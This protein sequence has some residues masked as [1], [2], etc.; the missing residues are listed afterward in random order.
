M[1]MQ[2]SISYAICVHNEHEELKRLLT[3]LISGIDETDE[4]VI[5]GDQGKVTDEVVSV[6]H[7][8][9]KN[10]QVKYVEFPLRKNFAAFKN[11]LFA[12]CTKDWI[13]QVDADEMVGTELLVNLKSI[14]AENADIEMMRVSRV[15][16]VEGLTQEWVNRWG[17]QVNNQGWV[18]WPDKQMRIVRNNGSIRWKNKVHEVLSGYQSWSDLP[19]DPDFSLIHVKSIDRQKKQN[20]FYSTI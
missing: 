7:K 12:N 15:N 17:W 8:F 13:F 10:P 4:I 1:K 18:N 5:Q 6:L 2:N 14:L 3:Q 9:I 16:I 20:E 11:N 19:T